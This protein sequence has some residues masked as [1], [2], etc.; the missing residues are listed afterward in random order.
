MKNIFFLIFLGPLLLA[1]NFQTKDSLKILAMS[2]FKTIEVLVN[3]NGKL[4]SV[5]RYS[6]DQNKNEITIQNVSDKNKEWIKT[7]I[8]LDNDYKIKEEE[9]ITEGMVISEKENKLINKEVSMINKYNYTKN[10]I[11]VQKFNSNGNLSTKEFCLI[12]KENRI[13][14]RIILFNSHNDIV[15]DGIERYN[16]ID[17]KSYNYEKLTFTFPRTQIIGVYSLN[18]Y[19]EIAS[20]KGSMT[21]NDKTELFD[22]YIEKKLKQFDSKGNLIKVYTLENNKENI[23]EVRKIV[24]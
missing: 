9:R 12:D 24:Y 14:E 15:V 23:L 3:K 8:K 18:S 7:I 6:Y 4:N 20:F 2:N 19:N 13:I 1:Q 16:W 21:A 5:R 17:D 10:T 11:Q 22:Y